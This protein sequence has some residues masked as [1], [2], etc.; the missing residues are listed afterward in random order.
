VGI[1]VVRLLNVCHTLV[2]ISVSLFQQIGVT[3]VAF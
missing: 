2:A 3:E 1:T